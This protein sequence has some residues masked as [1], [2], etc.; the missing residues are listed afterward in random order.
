MYFQEHFLQ[1]WRKKRDFSYKRV[2]RH[3]IEKDFRW[4]LNCFQLRFSQFTYRN[5]SP[6]YLRMQRVPYLSY[7]F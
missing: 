5:I 6:I 3:R 4:H 2:F 7:L 1:I